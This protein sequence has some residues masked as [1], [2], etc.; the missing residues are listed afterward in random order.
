MDRLGTHFV[1]DEGCGAGDEGQVY[2]VPGEITGPLPLSA[3]VASVRIVV[4][5]LILGVLRKPG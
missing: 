3:L 5:L 4:L 2:A 1:P